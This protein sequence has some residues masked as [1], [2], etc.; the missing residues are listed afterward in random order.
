MKK[1][2]L[3]FQEAFKSDENFEREQIVN[4]LMTVIFKDKETKQS[5]Q[6]FQDFKKKFEQEIAKRGIDGLIEHTNCE[7]YFRKIN[8]ENQLKQSR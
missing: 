5:I 2:I 1:I 4:S 6:L 8:T 3:I 7:D